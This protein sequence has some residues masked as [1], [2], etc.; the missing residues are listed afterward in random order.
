MYSWWTYVCNQMSVGSLVHSVTTLVLWKV[1]LQT[2]R[3]HIQGRSRSLVMFVS[4]SVLLKVLSQN[5][6][7]HILGMSVMYVTIRIRR[8]VILYYIWEHIQGKSHTP[9][10]YVSTSFRIRA[11]SLNIWKRTI[12][13]QCDL[14]DHKLQAVRVSWV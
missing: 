2:I 9:V 4:I 12:L 13:Y 14:C 10:T 5:I 7:E 1:I 3:E 11:I 6:Q 8:R